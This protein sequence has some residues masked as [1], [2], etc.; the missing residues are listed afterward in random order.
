[1]TDALRIMSMGAGLHSTAMTIKYGPIYDYVYF[2]DTLNEQPETYWYI[3][4]YLKP[5]FHHLGVPWIT[6]QHNKKM[7]VLDGAIEN[8]KPNLFFQQRQC[9]IRHKILPIQRHLRSL[10]NRPT[11]KNPVTVDIGFTANESLRIGKKNKSQP[12]YIKNNYP[13]MYDGIT[14]EDAIQIV[15]DHGW[16]LPVKS[17]CTFCPYAGWRNMRNLQSTDPATFNTLVK[18]EESDP[19][20]PKRSIYQ[21][22]PLRSLIGNGSL[23]GFIQDA[24]CDEGYCHDG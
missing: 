2:A 9:T 19:Q 12:K 24:R 5:H 20:F 18:L 14:H 6:V 8:G 23:D 17:G 22:K 3:E 10:P 13:L 7:S 11:H 21:N 1:M 16:P 4:H 15:K